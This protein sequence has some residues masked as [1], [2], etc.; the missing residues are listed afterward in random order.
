MILKGYRILENSY[1]G[2]VYRNLDLHFECDSF[3]GNCITSDGV[4][5]FRCSYKGNIDA[6]KDNL[7][8]NSLYDVAFYYDKEAK[9]YFCN[10]L[11]MK[12]K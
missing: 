1:N 8:I 7:V 4:P 12:G 11:Y 5:V 2:K 9:R 3:T 6:I 10:G